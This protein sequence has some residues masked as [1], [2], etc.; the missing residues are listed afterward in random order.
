VLTGAITQYVLWRKC[1]ITSG[2][3]QF[4]SC[5]TF[6]VVFLRSVDLFVV[7]VIFD[8]KTR[9]HTCYMQPVTFEFEAHTH[10]QRE[11]YLSQKYSVYEYG[12]TTIHEM[13]QVARKGTRPITLVTL[14]K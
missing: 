12:S 13:W 11:L 10:T 5:D 7:S 14:N 2:D 8:L 4:I 1:N 6:S 3:H 9:Y